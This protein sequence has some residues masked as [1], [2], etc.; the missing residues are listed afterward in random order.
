MYLGTYPL[1]T[2]KSSVIVPV[3]NSLMVAKALNIDY[4]PTFYDLSTDKEASGSLYQEIKYWDLDIDEKKYTEFIPKT[5]QILDQYKEL[6]FLKEEIIL[7]CEC[8]KLELLQSEIKNKR[9]SER[10]LL[11]EEMNCKF[12]KTSKT[13]NIESLYLKLD[14]D[15]DLLKK[16]N[17]I[18]TNL[19][20]SM[21]K[22][23]VTLNDDIRVSRNRHTPIKYTFDNRDFNVDVDF[24]SLAIVQQQRNHGLKYISTS[25]KFQRKIAVQNSFPKNKTPLNSVLYSYQD[26]FMD[27]YKILREKSNDVNDLILLIASNTSWKKNISYCEPANLKKILKM[28]AER[29]KYLISRIENATDINN[30]LYLY[31]SNILN[32][33]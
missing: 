3:I 20:G 21:E 19:M 31:S 10:I 2:K 28:D 29:K 32:I 6:F 1:S 30:F 15:I 27:Q 11:D 24:F 17:L 7:T 14:I 25:Q 9:R 4:I 8:G 23:A 5:K 18:P 33:K 12:C 13:E 26:G 22:L 16:I